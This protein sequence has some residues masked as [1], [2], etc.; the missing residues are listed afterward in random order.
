MAHR[1]KKLLD[2][3]REAIRLTPDS[4]RTEQAYVTR[5]TRDIFFHDTR[6][7]QDTG[8]AEI[9]ACLT[10]LAGQQQVAASTQHQALSALLFLSRDV[11]R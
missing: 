11:L 8:A 3:V 6:H 4:R 7:R 5:I 2:Q 1:P 9:A 10:R